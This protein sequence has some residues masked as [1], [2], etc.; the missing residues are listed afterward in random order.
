M[1]STSLS[2]GFV[3]DLRED[4]LAAGFS[5]EA[6]AEFDKPGTIDAITAELTALG[7]T[8]ERIGNVRRLASQLVSGTRWD[9]V[10]NIAEGVKGFA[11]ESQVPALLDAY[12]IPYV[13]SDALTLAV[14]LHKGMT[15]SV[16]RDAGLPTAKFAVVE[17]AEFL[18]D[19]AGFAFPLFVKPVAEGTGKGVSAAGKITNLAEL[20]PLCHSIITRFDQPALMEEFLPGREFTVGIVGTGSKARSIGIMEVNL[21]A[22]AEPGVYSFDNKDKYED[23][24]RYSLAGDVEALKAADVALAAYR[25][26]G[27]R[28]GGRVDLRSDSRGVP[29]FM[30][31]NPLAGLDPIHSDLPI[32]CHL[33]GISYSQ[34]IGWIV[35]SAIERL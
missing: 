25:L 8:V 21:L 5:P 32:M 3:Y 2:I 31:I 23:R 20:G 10:F 35:N 19:V 33:Q 9:L 7:H 1:T 18:P 28:D 16:I 4:Y 6:A 29:H 27:C 26:L 14:S 24:V 12:D 34:L 13:F 30:E 22:N 17:D 11:R 15:K